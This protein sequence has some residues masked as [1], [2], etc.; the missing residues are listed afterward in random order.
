MCV[1]SWNGQWPDILMSSASPFHDKTHC[2][3]T[4]GLT[5]SWQSTLLLCLGLDHF[6]TK[7]IT[8]MSGSWSFHSVFCH[9]MVKHQT[10]QKCVLSCNGQEL[11]I[12][13]ICLSWNGQ[14]PGIVAVCFLTISWKNTHILCLVLVHFMTKHTATML[15][16]SLFHDKTHC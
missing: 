8:T 9:A 6:M 15:G 12:V 3:Y 14:A 7:H 4:W 1:L 11:D 5:I 2:Y 10:W 13:S 16:A